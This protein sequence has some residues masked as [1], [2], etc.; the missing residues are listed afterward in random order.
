MQ[1][2][3][4]L[5][6]VTAVWGDWHIS[7]FFEVNL[8][9]LLASRN[10]PALARHC[11]IEYVI[12][13][14]QADLPRLKKSSGLRSLAQFLSLGFRTIRNDRLRQPI[15]THHAIWAEATEHAKRDGALVLLMPPDVAWSDGSFEHIGRLL[16][17]GKKAIFMTYLRAESE[18]FTRAIAGFRRQ[19]SDAITIEGARLVELC[20]QALHPLMA[21]YSIDSS[22]FPIHPEM[23]LQ[24]VCGEGVACRVLAREMFVYDPGATALNE[25]RLLE[26]PLELDA[27]HVVADSDDLFAVSL[28]PIE[29]E[30]EWYQ[31]PRVADPIEISGWW[32]EYDS[33]I[34]DFIATTKIRWHTGTPTES[35]WRLRERRSDLFLRRAAALREG[36]RLW[37]MALSFG[38]TNVALLLA[39]A[40]EL[41]TFT[42]A[43]RGR[44]GA[45]IFLPING[46]WD[47]ST[48]R[49]EHLLAPENEH[50]FGSLISEHYVPMKSFGKAASLE[51]RLRDRGRVELI[52]AA[53]SRLQIVLDGEQLR[54][55]GARVLGGPT[56][57]GS[58]QIYL[59]DR[60]L[61]SP[62]R[63]RTQSAA[64]A[65][66]EQV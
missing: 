5:L 15:E 10:F 63:E 20:L 62:L 19:G 26:S 24:P 66:V 37:R 60:L 55:N 65:Q 8:P 56:A 40:I 48:T 42:R 6:V 7:K 16:E 33:W 9:T 38:C 34:N 12:H 54:I 41:G 53:G 47:Q 22:H 14:S 39:T 64:S 51:D 50:C 13:S 17:V 45:L 58:H 23:M 28:A 1:R 4:K 11:D 52:S 30:F 46:A 18:S 43:V 57:C 29:K 61:A 35:A 21:A 3:R 59:V 2:R 49:P 25:T 32:L 44:G 31:W 27:M 36:R